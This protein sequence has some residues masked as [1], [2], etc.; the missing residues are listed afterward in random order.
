ME[1]H[2][3]RSARA[4]PARITH[5]KSICRGTLVAVGQLVRTSRQR[6]RP[7]TVSIA[8]LG[9]HSVVCWAASTC[10]NRGIAAQ[11]VPWTGRPVGMWQEGLPLYKNSCILCGPMARLRPPMGPSW[12]GRDWQVPVHTSSL[13]LSAVSVGLGVRLAA[14]PAAQHLPSASPLSGD[15]TSPEATRARGPALPR[16]F[17]STEHRGTR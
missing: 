10:R 15:R 2:W 6:H 13:Q 3:G 16:P 11:A 7:Q 8:G 4:F 12:V 9:Y 14:R 5:S 17:A 1:S